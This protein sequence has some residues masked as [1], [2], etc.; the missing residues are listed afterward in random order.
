MQKVNFPLFQV[1]M[2]TEDE[3]PKMRHEKPYLW[4]EVLKL[5]HVSRRLSEASTRRDRERILSDLL[6]KQLGSSD[7]FLLNESVRMAGALLTD[8]KRWVPRRY[9]EIFSSEGVI[10]FSSN[11]IDLFLKW[12]EF[13]DKARKGDEL[14]RIREFEAR[15]LLYLAMLN[16]QIRLSDETEK[17][18][19]LQITRHLEE[20]FFKEGLQDKIILSWHDPADKERAKE[21]RFEGEEQPAETQGLI[22]KKTYLKCRSFSFGGGDYLVFFDSRLKE[23]MEKLRKMLQKAIPDPRLINTDEYGLRFVFF[24]KKAL[25]DGLKKLCL[26]VWPLPFMAWNTSDN[27]GDDGQNRGVKRDIHS[28]GN[29]KALKFE[30]ASFGFRPE[31]IVQRIEDYLNHKCSQGPEVH[32][33]YRSTQLRKKVFPLIFPSEVYGVNWEDEEVVDLMEKIA[34]AGIID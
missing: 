15:R 9:L 3:M 18:E 7:L 6:K 10:A 5:R 8:L 28:S 22:L 4:M 11:Y 27:T 23:N 30:V 13:E 25:E 34:L 26:E 32:P 20:V 21:W 1:D 31:V 17:T 24:S 33:F 16:L 29:Y 14:S 12:Q 19:C 2:P